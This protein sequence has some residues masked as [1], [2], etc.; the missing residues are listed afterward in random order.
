MT[1]PA[2]K[3]NLLPPGLVS[4][5]QQVLSNRKPVAGGQDDGVSSKPE[6]GE[7]D[8]ALTSSTG[9]E[10]GEEND[11]RPII[12]V[13]NSDGIESPGLSCLLDA[14]V[15]EG[16]YNVHV[17]VPQSDKSTSGHSVSLKET[18][19]VV[20]T[21]F[22]GAIAYEISGTPVDCV[23]LALSG[24][25]F[26]WSK[27]L[28]V[29]SG[30]NKG[31]SCGHHTF[32]SGVV[33]GAREALINGVPSIAISLNWKKDGSEESDFKDA[34]SVCLPIIN[35]TARDIEKG[36]FPKGFSLDIQIPT[37]PSA[38][39]GIKVTKRSLFRSTLCWQA[40]SGTRNQ[41]ASRFGGG[42]PGIGMQ[43][44]Q[45]GRDA[46]AAGAA[47]RLATQKKNIEV[48]ESVG[49]VGKSDFKRVTK[50]FRAEMLDKEQNEE[51]DD[52]D[53]RALENGFVSVTPFSPSV[54]LDTETETA[55][56]DWISSVL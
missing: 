52:L 22:S 49:A 47:R 20:S 44:A 38:N 8:S 41:A 40:I 17:V 3:N 34:V 50:Y 53:F 46:S 23:S 56:S 29:I 7:D 33:A 13:T 10:P 54:H 1:T 5:L 43:F 6:K 32:Y 45:L 35:A 18:V 2:L 27:P 36:V 16:I 42:Q 51:D 55:A 21:E 48:V 9:D 28:L 26:S 31:S 11:S 4:N 12:L 15:R 30:I 39:K 25:L 14:L 37:S 19:E 24:A